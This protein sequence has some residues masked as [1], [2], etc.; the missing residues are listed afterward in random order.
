PVAE[1]DDLA[2]VLVADRDGSLCEHVEPALVLHHTDIGVADACSFH[3][4]KDFARSGGGFGDLVEY[5]R[6][7]CVCELPSF[8][9]RHSLSDSGPGSSSPCQTHTSPAPR[10]EPGLI[11]LR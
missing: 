1:G 8:H 5:E 2:R 11:D 3:L 4:Q 10:C 6:L 9:C 7:V